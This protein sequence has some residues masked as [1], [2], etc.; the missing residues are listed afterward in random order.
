MKKILFALL[1]L[2]TL[3][4]IT[5]TAQNQVFKKGNFNAAV[6][7][8]VVPTYFADNA[9]VNVIPVAAKLGY[10]FTDNFSMNLYTGF[11]S[12]TSKMIEDFEGNSRQYENDYLIIGLRPE[13]HTARGDKFDIYGGFMMGYNKAFINEM[14]YA[15]GD[16]ENPIDAPISG[17][18]T[19]NPNAKT[20]GFLFSGFV[21]ATYLVN[22][23]LGIFGELGYGVSL[24]QLGATF[25]L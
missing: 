21:G 9:K 20:G 16:V 18:T 8:G 17:P 5:I 12:S 7:I 22:P 11:S 23:K 2:F 13:L 10:N 4:T 24:V 14:V 25:K 15:D 3:T 1:T 19:R 6:G